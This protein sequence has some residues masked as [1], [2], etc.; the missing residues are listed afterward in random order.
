MYTSLGM[1]VRGYNNRK[2]R[3]TRD[4]TKEEKGVS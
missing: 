3:E 2:V 1:L 4:D